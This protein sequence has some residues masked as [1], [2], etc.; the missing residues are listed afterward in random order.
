MMQKF[1]DSAMALGPTDDDEDTRRLYAWKCFFYKLL[2]FSYFYLFI[3][4]SCIIC[5]ISVKV[6]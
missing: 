3:I 1:W 4:N 2:F 6:P 5:A